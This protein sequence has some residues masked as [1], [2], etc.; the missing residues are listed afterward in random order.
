[1][2]K[3]YKLLMF[4]MVFLLFNK[5]EAVTVT[6]TALA[7]NVQTC[8]KKEI[9]RLQFSVGNSGTTGSYLDIKLPTGFTFDGIAYGPIV[10]GGSGSNT[11]TYV[12]IVGGKHRITFGSSTSLQVIRLG[13][14][15]RAT[16]A[17]G[18]SS[19]TAQD[20]LFFYEGTGTIN[21]SATNLFNGSSP[22]L[23]ITNINNSPS[24]VT[25][26]TVV[27]RKY[28]VTNGGFGATSNF[29]IVDKCATAGQCTI[30]TSSF[31]INPSGTNYSI[32]VS[33]VTVAGD[34]IIV[35]FKNTA[36][37]KI[38]DADTF[39]ENSESFEL[40]YQLTVNTCGVPTIV[41]QLMAAWRCPD[42]NRCTYYNV[43]TGLSTYGPALPNIVVAQRLL[44]QHDCFDGTT[45]W[46]DTLVLRNTGGPATSI[47]MD[48]GGTY[49]NSF[50]VDLP[51]AYFDTASF[52]VKIGKNGTRYKPAYTII[53]TLTNTYNPCNY[54]GKPNHIRFTI[55]YL[56]SGDSLY[57]IM[58]QV[59]CNYDQ[60]CIVDQSFSVDRYFNGLGVN[61]TYKNACGNATYDGGW[62]DATTWRRHYT[63][64]TNS[65]PVAIGDGQTKDLS[66]DIGF[67]NPN[68]AQYL[69][70]G[71]N[72]YREITLTLPNVIKLDPAYANPVYFDHPSNGT[73]L[74]YYKSSTGDTFK[75]RINNNFYYLG[76]VFHAKVKGVC[77]GAT[78]SGIL[79]YKITIS[80]NP[81]TTY[82]TRKNTEICL[83]YPIAWT[84]SCVVCCPKGMV[85][86]RYTSDRINY[87]K[88]DHDN[89]GL[90]SGTLDL[91]KIN[92]KR[93]IPGDTVEYIHK[94][95]FK[96]DLTD[97][98]WKY[99]RS[100][101]K[102]SSTSHFAVLSDSV[103][104]D[105]RIGLDSTFA[106]TP[107]STAG[108]TTYNTDISFMNDFKQ[109]D[110]VTVKLK[111]RVLVNSEASVVS[112]NSPVDGGA[113][114]D[115]FVTSYACGSILDKLELF[116]VDAFGYE[117]HAGT[118]YGCQPFTFY[119]GFYTR[120]GPGAGTYNN[121]RFPY[122]YRP[123]AIPLRM[124]VKIPANYTVSS[125]SFISTNYPNQ[126]A[127]S[128]T[129]PSGTSIPFTFVDNVLNYDV[130]SL[131][132]PYGGNFIVPDEGANIAFYVTIVPTCNTV[133]GISQTFTLLDSF[134]M[135]TPLTRSQFN[136]ATSGGQVGA[137]V[138]NFHPNLIFSS[139]IP[140]ATAYS[141]VVSWP[142][143]VNNL[144]S[145]AADYNWL[146][147]YNKS[148]QIQIDSLKEGSTLL[149][150]D[151]NGF[152]RIGTVAAGG[153]RNFTV[154]GK[155]NS[156]VF[157]SLDVYSSWSCGG[158]YP[159][160]FYPPVDSVVYAGQTNLTVNGK[161][162]IPAG[163]TI[164][165]NANLKA[166][167]K[168]IIN[169]NVN[170]GSGTVITSE[171]SI[172]VL[173]PNLY[174]P[175]VTLK[176]APAGICNKFKTPLYVQPQPAAIQTQVTQLALTPVNPANGSSTAYGSNTI[177]MC[178]RIPFE[179]E[180]Q[181]TQSGNI[182]DVKEVVTLPFNGTTALDYVSDSGYI[183]YP[184]GTT[185]RKFSAAANTAILSQTPGG[186]MTLDLSQIDPVNFNS[187]S[188]LPGTGLG[189]STTRR[190]ILRWKMKSNCNLIS[191]EQWQPMQFANSA[192]GQPA[193]GDSTVTSG[194]ALALNGV[195]NPYVASITL[196]PT[197]NGCGDNITSIRIEKIGAGI[198]QPTD[199]IVLRLPKTVN[200]GA[201][202]CN[203]TACPSSSIAY[204]TSSDALYK[205]ISFPFPATAAGTGD[206]LR[207]NLVT[208]SASKSDCSVNQ[209]IKADVY[210]KLT[211]Y[212][213]SPIPSNLC[214]NARASLGTTNK[215]FNLQKPILNFT[216]YNS[217]YVYP[218]LYKYRFSGV[219]S[220]SSSTVGTTAGITLKTYFDVNNNLTYEKGIDA[221][222]RTTVLSSPINTNGTVTFS[223]SFTN[224]AYA[225]SPTLPLYTVIDTGDATANC[226]CGGIVKSAFNQ[227]LPLEFISVNAFNLNNQTGKVTWRVNADM[228]VTGFNVYRKAEGENSFT[229]VG[230]VMAQRTNAGISEYIYYNPI[231]NVANGKIYY[232]VEAVNTTAQI[233]KKSKTVSIIKTGSATN[234][235]VYILQPNSANDK[236]KII[237]SEGLAGA[238]VAITDLS[239]KIMYNGV[240]N[241][242]QTTLNVS[243]FAP[244]IYNVTVSTSEFS[245]TQ[246]LSVIR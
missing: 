53:G 65:G 240:I 145:F 224:G 71:N 9:V 212:C 237:L 239:G 11:A 123:L 186:T 168:V 68:S 51:G 78:C 191:G 157:D 66:L 197:V 137:T 223:D 174:W 69:A 29:I 202:T 126:P 208:R 217:T 22:S 31:V 81:D 221:L 42:L 110:T 39:F 48:A 190:A 246:K 152:Y 111:L 210:Q 180:I 77:D 234:A 107:T 44:R 229:K 88:A 130:R 46:R 204:K 244:G 122:E 230:Y 84:S 10:T 117:D 116:G 112:F 225:P 242:T 219:V 64:G 57:L 159:T 124:R 67:L 201:L 136:M 214:P 215:N 154:Y 86:L 184:I 13:F 17:A 41:S 119:N 121:I 238:S 167:G 125:V 162:I 19:Y 83:Q 109:G 95:Y 245:Q 128:S 28:T 135:L 25:L 58:G 198:P 40:Q 195:T 171:V 185:P 235:P 33:E 155:S 200:T 21:S 120:I 209:N 220:N 143:T 141:K 14:W 55:P 118:T 103:F 169:K 193:T 97:T 178:Q 232:N 183:E 164:P 196:S 140:I 54:T 61:F 3:L 211:L 133:N 241:D 101:M 59:Q 179:M 89:N 114:N 74:P 158:N 102:V 60:A 115:N 131:F 82:C 16:C 216:T 144:T 70:L 129:Y 151:A 15:Q 176:I 47:N 147:P 187:N 7:I 153:T 50:R 139:A 218:S 243:G 63:D 182:Y 93:A 75:F 207:Y 188:G 92:T 166:T 79:Q 113:S 96:T 192:C 231:S 99:A 226:F 189:T 85:N 35:R 104:V 213:G 106:T 199:S 98:A 56:G 37:T 172:D 52:Y 94:F 175:N 43:N 156:C 90:P 80:H 45:V 72:A 150:P 49:G 170:I 8:L 138:T 30:N 12:G 177:G 233:S 194:Y 23:S 73:L 38:G 36:I 161:L 163:A 1:M 160:A 5:G 148:G 205:Y 142:F 146:Y 236:V 18:T 132:A 105:R 181:S 24:S 173:P 91:T 6:D 27:T 20:S 32:P 26:G 222:V 203:G 34:S 149:T 76:T 100:L 134:K 108:N 87:G 2:N 165:A 62:A 227:A 206:T 4:V 127:G 228:D